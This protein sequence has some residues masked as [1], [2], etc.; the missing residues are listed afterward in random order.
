MNTYSHRIVRS[1][2]M[3]VGII[4]FL[5]L[6]FVLSGCGVKNMPRPIGPETPPEIRDLK[7]QVR[8]KGVELSWTIPNQMNQL[9]KG[10]RC[11]FSV[12]RSH[13]AWEKRN[14]AEC[15]PPSREEIASIDPSFP[16]AASI[17]D[18][19][20]LWMDA[21][22]SRLNAYRYQ[23]TI[24]DAKGT[25]LTESNPV[26]ANVYTPPGA[27]KNLSATTEP[28]GIVLRWKPP[29][30]DERGNPLPAEAQ[31]LLD[32][33]LPGGPWEKL[34]NVPIKANT[35][36]DQNMASEESY[37][38][39]VTSILIVDGTIISG[40]PSHVHDAK[41]PASLPPPPP[42]R[43][44]S[45]PARGGMEVHWTETQ[46]KV[47][48]YHVYRR[49]GKEII[50][51]TSTPVQRPP[52]V[53]TSVKRNTIYFYAVSAVGTQLDHKEGLLSKWFEIRSLNFE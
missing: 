52:Y 14:C 23:V 25:T 38:Y 3:A 51:L 4:P 43:V 30:S 15:P 34:S 53:D 47:V 41:S 16:G 8:S 45:I 18:K 36:L 2:E 31:F 29:V 44:W 50:R 49:E 37:D 32:R 10:T 33:H 7:A 42:N 19:R 27:V 48:G 24:V 26:I 5:L 20:I 40:E 13:L 46:G 6:G 11:R 21:A 12:Q 35:F 9:S 22:V 17:E 28:Q 39:R 1:T